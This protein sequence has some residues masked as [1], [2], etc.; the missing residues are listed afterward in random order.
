MC[1]RVYAD[2]GLCSDRHTERESMYR[3]Y[4]LEIMKTLFLISSF[5]GIKTNYNLK[6]VVSLNMQSTI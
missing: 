3:V 5:S 4:V 1:V 2:A 6:L